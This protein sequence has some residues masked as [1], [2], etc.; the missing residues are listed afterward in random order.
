MVLAAEHGREL[1]HSGATGRVFGAGSPARREDG[2]PGLR[3]NPAVQGRR[4]RPSSIV[5]CSSCTARQPRLMASGSHE[6]QR[7]GPVRRIPRCPA[8]RCLAGRRA[9]APWLAG[10]RRGS[11]GRPGPCARCG[12]PRTRRAVCQSNATRAKEVPSSTF[13]K[14][15]T[16]GSP[17][18]ESNRRPSHYH[19]PPS[20]SVTAG[21]PR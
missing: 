2:R 15:G 4:R 10:A 16:T 11:R 12:L 17:L 7:A 9:A 18:T 14:C 8:R 6:P 20:S 5:C 21:R 3:I 19:E 1:G 13:E